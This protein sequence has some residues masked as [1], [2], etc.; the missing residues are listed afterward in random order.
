MVILNDFTECLV[1]F[2][3]FVIKVPISIKCD[4]ICDL[5]KHTLYTGYISVNKW[6][7]LLNRYLYGQYY[8]Y[9]LQQG[10]FSQ[11]EIIELL[12]ISSKFCII[13]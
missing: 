7:V 4:K 2:F 11:N 13:L 6:T 1:L 3:E 5:M 9:L 10:S 12:N 8:G